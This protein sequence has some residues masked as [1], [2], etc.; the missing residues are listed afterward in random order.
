MERRFATPPLEEQEDPKI[1]LSK[2]TEIIIEMRDSLLAMNF[3][4]QQLTAQKLLEPPP[5]EFDASDSAP[6]K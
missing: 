4:L 2:L 6:S 1:D 3:Q 5:I